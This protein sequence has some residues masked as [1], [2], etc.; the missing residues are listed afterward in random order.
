[1]SDVIDL[2]L[3]DD[4][5]L[6]DPPLVDDL[7]LDQDTEKYMIVFVPEDRVSRNQKEVVVVPRQS[8]D[9]KRIELRLKQL[10]G[11][12]GASVARLFHAGGGDFGFHLSDG[13]EVHLSDESGSGQRSQVAYVQLQDLGMI[14][15]VAFRQDQ[16]LKDQTR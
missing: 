3:D 10:A 14:A 4:S 9:G 6:V 5:P 8:E 16:L 1:M 15:Q 13:R 12:L 11:I 7:Y 2:P